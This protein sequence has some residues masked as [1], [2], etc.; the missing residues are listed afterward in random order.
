LYGSGLRS[1]IEEGEYEDEQSQNCAG[2]NRSKDHPTFALGLFLPHFTVGKR[3]VERRISFADPDDVPFIVSFG[4]SR[5][6]CNWILIV[7]VAGLQFVA[8]AGQSIHHL[9]RRLPLLK[10]RMII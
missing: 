3:P 2:A 9:V 1:E 7:Q 5:T 10:Q 4:L 6:G 8:R